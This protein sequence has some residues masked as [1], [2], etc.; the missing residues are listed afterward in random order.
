MPTKQELKD[1]AFAE[2]DSRAEELIN[3]SKHI[4]ANPE[5]GFREFKTAAL[6]GEQFAA[7]GVPF[8]SGP[9]NDGPAR[10]NHR[11]QRRAEHGDHG[12]TGQPDRQRAPARR[13]GNRRGPR[14]RASLP[15][16]HDAGSHHGADAGRRPAPPERAHI[17]HG[18]AGRG[19]HRDRVPG[20]VAPG[21]QDRVPGRQAG[22][23][24]GWASSTTCT[25]R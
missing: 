14:L 25:W 10:R 1:R 3:L 12:R 2:I 20:P 7:M 17:A 11:R 24:Q 22:V 21:R 19:I 9:G 6:V 15:D 23:H 4:L 16:R 5:P 18:R 13:R 8:R